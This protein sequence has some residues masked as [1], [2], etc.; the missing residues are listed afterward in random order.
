MNLTINHPVN[1]QTNK[2]TINSNLLQPVFTIINTTDVSISGFNINSINDAI[3][4][5][6]SKQL[7]IYNNI[8]STKANGINLNQIWYANIIN[9]IILNNINSGIRIKQ[10]NYI[11]IDNNKINNTK[12]DGI[13]IEGTVNYINI[14][15]NQITN[16]GLYSYYGIN[17]ISTNRLDKQNNIYIY[18]NNLTNNGNG[19]N[20]NVSTKNLNI[21]EN[22]IVR[23]AKGINLDQGYR[24]TENALYVD[25]NAFIQ[26]TDLCI[27]A[28][29]SIYEEVG[30][31]TLGYNWFNRNSNN[32]FICPKVKAGILQSNIRQIGQNTY[33]VYFTEN[34]NEINSRR[35]ALASGA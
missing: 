34:G 6:N 7:N 14:T 30:G 13:I 24:K 8:I 28:R 27:D 26:G 1:I 32:G 15:N 17:L 18:N 2:T 3:L 20:V 4:G 22:S 10:S 35:R 29:G 12:Q 9:N 11:K 19:I 16:N 5:I 21:T 23:G 31:I 33:Q 25:Y